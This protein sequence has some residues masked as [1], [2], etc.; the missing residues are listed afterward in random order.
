M[1]LPPRAG[2]SEVASRHLP[3]WILGRH[4]DWEIIAASHTVA[5]TMSFSRY[6]RDLV[7]SDG[8]TALFPDAAISPYSRA[9]EHWN[10]TQGGG[11]M[12]AGRGSGIS[13][14]GA[15]VLLLDD[16]F[17][18]IEEAD[19]PTI[20]D[21]VWEWYISTAYTRLAPGGG[22]IG[23]MTHWHEDD[24]CG[25]IIE[26]ME[27]GDGDRFE[28]VRYPAINEGGDEYILPDDTIVEVPDGSPVPP[29]ARRT[30]PKGTAIHPA[31]YSTE[32][33]LRIKR[34]AVAA[35][36]KRMW[37]SLYQ[38][39]PIPDEGNYFTREML[40]V[41]GTAP[42]RTDLKIYQAWDFAISEGKES[43]Y[44]VGVTIGVDAYDDVYVLD[45]MRFKTSDGLMLIETVVDYARRWQPDALGVEDGQIWKALETQFGKVC[46]ERRYY[47]AFDVLKPLTDKLSRASPLRGRMQ[48]GRVHFPRE[49]GWMM[50]MRREL[51]HFPAGKNDDIV[52]ALAWAVRLTLTRSAP[53][54]PGP[55]APKSWK[56]RLWSR[57]GGGVSHMA[58]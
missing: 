27:S 47:P 1:M 6:V 24:W 51:M 53:R 25:R 39:N 41:Y 46:A 55:T 14:H 22:V 35:G 23:L 36:L 54:K 18:T 2:K 42:S 50:D 10:L 17:S 40:R 16:L 48:A 15:H 38:Q 52:D 13:G 44:N 5:L 57:F 33:M 56:D 28:V 9:I 12:A 37:D 45:M 11:Y 4:P 58:A 7:L 20:R 3:A 49:A 43:D 29:G 19:S 32:A 8:F 21:N 30:R 34:N 31:R 26:A